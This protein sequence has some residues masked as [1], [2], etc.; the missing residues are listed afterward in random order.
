MLARF[1]AAHDQLAAQEFLVVQFLDGP[2]RF[3]DRQH[4]D[5]GKAFR[6]LIVLVGHDLRV[7]HLADAV[8]ELE[9]V[10]LGR[11]E[12]KIPDVKTRAS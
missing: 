10:A 6:T 3:F 4:L 2:F 11:F 5:E 7:L 1:R 8:E 9:Q 12:G